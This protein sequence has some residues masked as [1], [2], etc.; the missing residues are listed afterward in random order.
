MDEVTEPP[1]ENNITD[2]LKRLKQQ[3]EATPTPKKRHNFSPFCT[4]V[5]DVHRLVLEGMVPGK[6]MDTEALTARINAFA[7]EIE[8]LPC[9]LSPRTDQRHAIL[10]QK[11]KVHD[12][13]YQ[14]IAFA[15]VSSWRRVFVLKQEYEKRNFQRNMETEASAQQ[16]VD[17]VT[18]QMAPK[19]P[20]QMSRKTEEEQ[21]VPSNAQTTYYDSHVAAKHALEALDEVRRSMNDFWSTATSETP[22]HTLEEL[23]RQ[24]TRLM[25]VAVEAVQYRA[26]ARH[27]MLEEEQRQVLPNLP[28]E[29][30]GVDLEDI[31][32][33]KMQV[34][35]T[36]NEEKLRRKAFRYQEIRE[37]ISNAVVYEL[38][39]VQKN[40]CTLYQSM[41]VQL[42]ACDDDLNI[43][44]Q[45]MKRQK[46][47]VPPLPECEYSMELKRRQEVFRTIKTHRFVSL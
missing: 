29:E 40:I 13:A 33:L 36:I 10:L 8:D 31:D 26:V 35:G 28:M 1:K 37:M 6:I 38:S 20:R 25:Q 39:R 19:Q 14:M 27:R 18:S 7:G 34:L 32:M 11:I 2:Q 47:E 23:Q 45:Q 44:E 17:W 43:I 46:K 22:V 5:M 16:W 21:T 42:Q 12:Q 4:W 3:L 9:P 15:V 24:E 41:L 30:E